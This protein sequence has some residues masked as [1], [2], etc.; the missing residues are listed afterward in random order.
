MA[1][2]LSITTDVLPLV[3]VVLNLS[4][5]VIAMVDK[6]H[7]EAHDALRDLRR[8]LQNL[9]KGI[10]NIQKLLRIL[11]SDPKN[12]AVEKLSAL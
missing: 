12:R 5:T 9:I 8:A 6:T 2:P 10:S 3:G 11:V 7:G 1:G 4:L